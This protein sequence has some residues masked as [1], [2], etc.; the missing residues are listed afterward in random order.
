MTK[1][2]AML[3]H[4]LTPSIGN[5]FRGWRKTLSVI[6]TMGGVQWKYWY[7]V[8]SISV[9][10]FCCGIFQ[11]YE[12]KRLARK[13]RETSF[14]EEPVFIIGHWRSGTTHLHNIL[15]IDPQFGY[16]TTIQSIFPHAYLTNPLLSWI[17]VLL[18]PPTRP[19]DS[20]KIYRDSPQEEEMALL[21][22]GSSAFYNFW[23]TP[24]KMK[25]WYKKTI[26]FEMGSKE[27]TTWLD[28]YVQLLRK[29]NAAFGGKRLVLKN[30]ANTARIPTLLKQFPKAKFIFIHRNPYSVY[31]STQKLHRNVVSM[32]CL[33]DYNFDT[34]KTGI[35]YV[36]RDLLQQ[37]LQTRA[38][39]PKENLIEVR[40]QD[41]LES[42][43]EKIRELYDHLNLGEFEEVRPLF[44]DYLSDKIGY[45]PATYDIPEGE[46]KILEEQWKFSFDEW[47]YVIEEGQ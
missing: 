43:L 27:E 44:E 38:L 30:P 3:I 28:S 18:M 40:F 23:F 20:M 33:Q 17:A 8:F 46:R 39:V 7:R 31:P 1:I 15:S 26:R 32:F 24:D 14:H 29:T 12:R 47:G 11:Y 41:L 6:K 9:I 13:I 4:V 36:Y 2:V 10:T 45:K 37:Y 21:N 16:V 19:F 5:T 25:E 34:V 42:P 22:Y 35:Q